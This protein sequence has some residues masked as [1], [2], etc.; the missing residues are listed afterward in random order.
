[1]DQEENQ[2]S[3]IESDVIK[4]ILSMRELNPSSKVDLSKLQYDGVYITD[5]FWASKFPEGYS[6]IPEM[7]LVIDSI[8]EKN[9]NV[10]PLDEMTE[11]IRISER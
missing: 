7:K 2:I 8:C 10:S 11:R 5:A 9:K 6:E 3:H 1:M 4:E